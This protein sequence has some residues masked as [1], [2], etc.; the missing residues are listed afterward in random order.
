MLL[1]RAESAQHLAEKLPLKSAPQWMTF[2]NDNARNR[3]SPKIRM[4]TGGGAG[5][6]SLYDVAELDKFIKN[7]KPPRHLNR[8]TQVMDTYGMHHRENITSHGR[9]LGW[10]DFEFS[11]Y[12]I[13]PDQQDD[14][15]SIQV[16]IQTGSDSGLKV[17]ALTL[18]EA[19]AWLSELS[20]A[21]NA[22][23]RFK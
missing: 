17:G 1:T 6:K 8:T 21:I 7:I 4:Q 19:K 12:P 2:L 16:H 13:A 14:G 15:L 18:A 11:A 23:E 22:V 20:E 3:N 9:A 10:R 5:C